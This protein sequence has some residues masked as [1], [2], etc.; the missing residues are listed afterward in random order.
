MI[1]FN[2]YKTFTHLTPKMQ[3]SFG[4]FKDS[5]LDTNVPIRDVKTQYVRT[6][7]KFINQKKVQEFYDRTK[8]LSVDAE[9]KGD[10]KLSSLLI[11]ELGKL[12]TQ[13]KLRDNPENILHKAVSVCRQS[14][15]GM[16]E[17]ARL[18]DLEK[19]YMRTC[20]DDKLFNVLKAKVDCCK[21]ILQNYQEYAEHFSSVSKKPTSPNSIKT[22]LSYTYAAL[23]D[24]LAQTNHNE[25][26]RLLDKS[27][28]INLELGF[29]YTVQRLQGRINTIIKE[30]QQRRKAR[31]NGFI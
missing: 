5:C 23:A 21:K 26:I 22:Q 12:S 30:A 8:L 18:G 16:H 4:R 28:D 19:L 1:S 20:E 17:L 25:A 29:E 27:I 2:T 24:M 6:L 10:T 3:K 11:N 9:Q 7:R 31:Y 14:D 15:D 13:F